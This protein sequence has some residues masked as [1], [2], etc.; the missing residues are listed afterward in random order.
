MRNESR[1]RKNEP[2]TGEGKRQSPPSRKARK[3][4]KRSDVLQTERAHPEPN[5]GDADDEAALRERA[6]LNPK[7]PKAG[8]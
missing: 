8:R 5:L 2:Q 1:T 7:R 6:G 3:L 4:M